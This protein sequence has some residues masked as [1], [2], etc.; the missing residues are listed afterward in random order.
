M[1]TY[2]FKPLPLRCPATFLPSISSPLRKEEVVV[3]TVI[4]QH[5]SFGRDMEDGDLGSSQRGADDPAPS[6][7]RRSQ[8]SG[9]EMHSWRL[10]GGWIAD[11]RALGGGRC[12]PRW[13]M[14]ACWLN[15]SAS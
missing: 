11:V 4:T 6:V 15:G 2:L 13:S 5:H 10:R 14:A 8:S 12:V 9:S 7:L 1:W 3:T